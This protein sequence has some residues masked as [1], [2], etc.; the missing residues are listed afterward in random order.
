VYNDPAKG[1]V[2]DDVHSESASR[3]LAYACTSFPSSIQFPQNAQT[4]FEDD[5]FSAY[6][7]ANTLQKSDNITAFLY[8]RAMR[9]PF[10][11]FNEQTGFME[12]RNKDGSWAGDTRGWTEG[13][14]L[15]CW[16]MF[17]SNPILIG[18]KWAYSFDVVHAIPELIKRR[19]GKA[20]FLRSLEVHF[21]GAHNEHTN[22]V[23][24]EHCC[25]ALVICSPVSSHHTTFHIS[26]RCQEQLSKHRNE[27]VKSRWSTIITLRM[28]CP[29]YVLRSFVLASSHQFSLASLSSPTNMAKNRMR[30]VAR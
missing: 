27:S 15:F 21:E 8:E 20:G 9:T 6:V 14:S 7:L 4:G 25:S 5:D 26:M 16:Y 18:D 24:L 19:G 1:W 28:D 10:T 30:T 22:E 13:D 23:H 17:A 3:T 2:A 29:G 11:L 12:A